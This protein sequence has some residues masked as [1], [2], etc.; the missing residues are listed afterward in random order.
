ML[1]G[2][3][4]E[5]VSGQYWQDFLIERQFEPLGMA[6]TRYDDVWEIVPGRAR[7]YGVEGQ[8]VVNIEYDDHSAYA[9]GG[10]RSTLGDLRTW[11]KA[12]VADHLI[13]SDLRQR[14]TTSFLGN[15][16]YGWQELELFGRG[17]YNHTGG[18]DGFVSHLAYYPSE[19]L[20][21]I[22][23]NNRAREDAKATACDLAALAFEA[24]PAPTGDA[25]WLDRLRSERC[26]EAASAEHASP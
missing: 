9:A 15:Y 19:E 2:Y 23:L 4:I 14:A 3:V 1:L 25:D 8:E 22:V 24:E 21:I 10:L 5:A 20:L 16:G 12:Y 17:M 13:G 18:I 7:G 26:R 11:H 6:D